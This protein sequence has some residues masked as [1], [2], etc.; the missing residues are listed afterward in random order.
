MK[1]VY[2]LN[3]PNLNMLGERERDIYGSETLKDIEE[4]CRAAAGARG[5][6]VEFRQS[7]VEGELVTWI[8]E[9]REK[10]C[11]DHINAAAY[12]HTSV[13]MHDALKL[14]DR[15]GGRGAP[16]Q[17]L[18]ARAVPASQLRVAGGDRGDLRLRRRRAMSWR[19][20]RSRAIITANEKG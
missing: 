19:S 11:G 9:A 2:V 6:D 10:A 18:Q 7:N 14:L 15:A 5:L 12:T 13:A 1:P 8:Q 20:R 3:G 16:L 17:H 4:R